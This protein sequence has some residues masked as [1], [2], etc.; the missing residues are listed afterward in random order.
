M[1]HAAAEYLATP[2]TLISLV[3]EENAMVG[4]FIGD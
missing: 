4:V 2:V 1:I 3:V